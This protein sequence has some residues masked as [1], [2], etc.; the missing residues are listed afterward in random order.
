MSSLV[1]PISAS[2]RPSRAYDRRD[3]RAATRRLVPNSLS[4][5]N[6]ALKGGATS[7]TRA[8]S[9]TSDETGRLIARHTGD[10]DGALNDCMSGYGGSDAPG[11][12]FYRDKILLGI[13]N[14]YLTSD[15]VYTYAFVLVHI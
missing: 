11:G 9:D 8:P 5:S 7:S 4:R 2:S 10:S 1:G 12:R 14:I 3:R 15:V 6:V 13:K